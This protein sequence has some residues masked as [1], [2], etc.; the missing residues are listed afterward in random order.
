M[1]SHMAPGLNISESDHGAVVTF[2]VMPF[3]E[4][5]Q[6]TPGVKRTFP[7]VL[8]AAAGCPIRQVGSQ[9]IMAE[10][11]SAYKSEDYKFITLPPGASEWTNSLGERNVRSV[12]AALGNGHP[13]SILEIGGGSTWV[14]SRLREIYAPK[15][16][17]LVDPSVREAAE[18]IEIFRD[19]FPH[20]G[21]TGRRF[22]LV[23]GFSV[24][25]HV[26]DPLFFLQ[27]IRGMLARKG[28][29][30]LAY[31]DCEEQLCRGDLNAL[32][33]EHLSYFTKE[34]SRWIV[35][36]AGFRVVSVDS[37][38]DLLT[39]VLEANEEE[40][41]VVTA[42]DESKLLLQGARMF[43]QLLTTTADRIRAC[44]AEGGGVG[45]HG[46]TQGLNSFLYMTRIGGHPNIR[47]YDG[48]AAK[49]G[50]FLPACQSPILPVGDGSYA[51]NS[52]LVISAMSFYEPIRRFAIE[53]AGIDPAKLLPLSGC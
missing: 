7:F 4:G 38:N 53:Q 6:E 41:G 25:E 13:E 21:I 32:L 18:G 17:V 48:D 39:L 22:D 36:A 14:A 30:V 9:Q 11:V 20:P 34:S 44:L 42:L 47:L 15:S 43:Q 26:P 40:S 2:D 29:V 3:W 45:F 10:V 12:K 50:K 23:L 37:R 33:H 19:Y 51:E 31:P 35:A 16:Y 52:L 46:A 5:V 27:Q 24:L 49:T 28:K 1:H 8:E